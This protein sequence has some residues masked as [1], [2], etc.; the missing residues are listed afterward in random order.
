MWDQSVTLNCSV[1]ASCAPVCHSDPVPKLPLRPQTYRHPKFRAERPARIDSTSILSLC[2]RCQVKTKMTCPMHCS[3]IW[4]AYHRAEPLCMVSHNDG[5]WGGVGRV[6]PRGRQ[7]IGK[8]VESEDAL[9]SLHFRLLTSQGPRLATGPI[10][11][12]SD[13]CSAPVLQEMAWPFGGQSRIC[14]VVWLC[15]RTVNYC[16]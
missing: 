4:F 16:R 15:G 12:L 3:P 8:D 14:L 9:L 10:N 11:E 5:R 7:I 13:K 2:P 6:G 1:C